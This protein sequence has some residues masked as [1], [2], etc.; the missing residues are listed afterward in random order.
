MKP[1]T[2][3]IS[4]HPLKQK[5]QCAHHIWCSC[6]CCHTA[7]HSEQCKQDSR[8]MSS[9]TQLCGSKQPILRCSPLDC[10]QTESPCEKSKALFSN[11]SPVL[12]SC[13]GHFAVPICPITQQKT[14]CMQSKAVK[15]VLGDA[16]QQPAG[17][18][19]AE[20]ALHMGLLACTTRGMHGYGSHISWLQRRLLL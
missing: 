9:L 15:L 12:S 10:M 6:K 2:S 17:S 4:R 13:V 1:M 3:T 8:A 18:L 11:C 19:L 20:Q 14:G 5:L 7:M 16:T